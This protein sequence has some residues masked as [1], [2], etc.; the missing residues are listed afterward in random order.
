MKLLL[1]HPTGNANVRNAAEACDDA[2]LLKTFATTV[3][4]F[5]NN[6]FGRL[7]NTN[8]GS[9]FNRRRYS[10]SLQSKTLQF[11]LRELVRMLTDKLGWSSLSRHEVGVFSVQQVYEAL[12]RAV[13]TEL[14]RNT[15]DA[16]YAY[17][18]GAREA[19]IA[20]KA[21]QIRTI[22]DLPT[23]YWRTA[24]RIFSEEAVLQPDWVQTMPALIDSPQKLE[25][26]DEELR[27]ADQI[28]V[29]SEFTANTLL[30]APFELPTPIII[31]YGCPTT[32]IS[33]QQVDRVS[34]DKLRVLFVGNLSQGKGIAYL[35]DAV[36]QL[37][38]AVELTLIGRRVGQCARLDRALEKHHWIDSLPNAQVLEAMRT[39]DVLVFP[40]IFEGFGMVIS[41][42]LSQGIPVITTPNTCAP[43]LMKDGKSGFIVPI[44]DGIAIAEKLEQ[45]HQDRDLL[46]QMKT[47]AL[48]VANN[49][50]WAN[51]QSQ[52]V[53]TLT[54]NTG[55]TL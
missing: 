6:I 7:T 37:G 23:G 28:I 42:A 47:A 9:S 32:P 45:L 26:K 31:P 15:Y 17:E 53:H 8:I 2:G 20:A 13:A 22:Y 35:L 39:H 16:V 3:A 44:R 5:D 48:E 33:D 27:A 34:H 14:K 12:D 49:N 43:T 36:E 51:Y 41:E 50:T 30:D 55:I 29:A 21:K 24:K 46:Q 1:T 40:S 18:D 4:A 52:L 54:A 38:S 25:R 19:F 11:P 10:N